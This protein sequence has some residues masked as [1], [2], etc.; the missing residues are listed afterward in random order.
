MPCCRVPFLP[1]AVAAL[2]AGREKNARKEATKTVV[3]SES[4]C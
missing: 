1:F 3:V 4:A 2:Q